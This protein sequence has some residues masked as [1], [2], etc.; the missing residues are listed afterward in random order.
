MAY[1]AA[2]HEDLART[3]VAITASAPD[4]TY[5]P[6]NLIS[7]DP[8]KQ[9]KLTT[10]GPGDFVLQFLT[11]VAPVAAFLFY[12]YLVEDLSVEIQGNDTDS[13]GSPAFSQAITIP[14]K[15]L[16]GP[17]YQKWTISPW[18]ILN[19][20]DDPT[21]YL[22]WRLAIL[23]T[24]DQNIAVGRLFLASEIHRV[25]IFEE[26]PEGE[27][28]TQIEQPTELDVETVVVIGG[29]RRHMS[30]LLIGTDLNAGTAPVQEASDFR[31]LCQS[32]EGR[33]HPFPWVPFED[34]DV[35]PVRAESPVGARTHHVGGYQ[36]W[37]FTVR[38][39]SRGL[40]WP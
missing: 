31:A 10:A 28:Q 11:K 29:P 26:I 36:L 17:T 23:G 40:P 21:G 4:P 24:N 32:S 5:P 8:A 35:W 25:E 2:P 30:P 3:A 38:E 15:R 20:L 7:E 12:P 6:E 37:P 14:A 1:Y 27:D 19:D 9:A 33:A 22:Y 16:D 13:W 34:N 39:V 18:V